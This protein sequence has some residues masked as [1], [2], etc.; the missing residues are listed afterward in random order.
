[1]KPDWRIVATTRVVAAVLAAAL[2]AGCSMA[3]LLYDR[4][5]W[6]VLR[7]MDR[8][9]DLRDIQREQVAGALAVSLSR[10][11][12]R[13][14]PQFEATFRDAAA[15]AARG[16][17]E[18][19]AAWA[20]HAARDMLAVSALELLA[21]L[22][23]ALVDLDAGQRAHLAERLAERNREFRDDHALDLP[24]EERL[25]RRAARTVKR[26]EDWTGPLSEE[27]LAL[28]T[29]VRDA[30]PDTASEWLA[31]SEQRQQ[32]LL[33]LL[34][35]GADAERV[36]AYLR[37]WWIELEGISTTFARKREQRHAGIINLLLRLDESLDSMQRAHLVD[38]LRDL[39]D[40]AAAL[41]RET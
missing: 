8:Y 34:D 5:D 10:H 21:P 25:E 40:D 37:G 2:L 35:S 33:A 4:A 36:G 20:L 15:R 13:H 12:A 39:A 22:S 26:V 24:R 41:T 16:L 14:L 19:D 3:R 18:D 9:L 23:A 17:D 28:V 38:R 6:L 31:Y 30:M 32:G 27:Q 7:E 29:A 11:R 1:V